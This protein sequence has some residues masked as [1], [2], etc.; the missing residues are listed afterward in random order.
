MFD[1]TEYWYKIWRK[2]DLRFQKWHEKFSKFSPGHFR[3]SKNLDIDGIFLS[4][5]EKCMSLKFTGSYVSW[6]WRMMKHL[7]R[8]WLVSS[9]LTLG[10]WRIVTQALKDLNNFH[11]N[12]LLL[13]KVYNVLVK[14]STEELCL[15]ALNVDAKF[16]GK[17]TCAFLNDRKNSVNFR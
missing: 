1:G 17:L 14:K 3:K 12:G 6:Q 15:M 2:T 8:N 13:A 4:K 7:K 5:V 9:K 16:E 11:F 10:I